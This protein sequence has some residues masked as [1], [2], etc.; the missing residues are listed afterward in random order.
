MTR[1]SRSWFIITGVALFIMRASRGAAQEG[2]PPASSTAS[3]PPACEKYGGGRVIGEH[4]FLVPQF[5]PSALVLSYLDTNAGLEWV[6]TPNFTFGRLGERDFRELRTFAAVDGSVAI[7]NQLAL[8]G[9][10][11]GSMTSG[12]NAISL[13]ARGAT[14]FVGGGVGVNWGIVRLE[15]SQTQISAR[16]AVNYS[17]G[18]LANVAAYTNSLTT[19]PVATLEDT[20]EGDA[21]RFLRSPA[22]DWRYTVSANVAQV[23][24]R[25]F[26][27]Q[28]SIG[29]VFDWRRLSVLTAPNAARTDIDINER[30]PVFG[31]ALT[32]DGVTMGV[33]LALLL[34]Y[35]VSVLKTINDFRGTDDWRTEHVLDVGLYYSG[36]RD[37]Q[38]GAS[39]YWNPGL[40][41]ITVSGFSGAESERPDA[42]GLALVLRTFW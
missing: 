9:S 22:H 2:P 28:L 42:M 18:A 34:E 24:S 32:G 36:R 26:S 37:L 8:L 40:E 13:I 17:T 11:N 12:T 23:L 35:Q 19:A 30:G 5:V 20:V 31:L 38:V 16:T 1:S 25:A 15:R 29:A 33:P 7:L 3:A 6:R 21:S 4:T 39:W 14:Y 10:L 27:A 41:P